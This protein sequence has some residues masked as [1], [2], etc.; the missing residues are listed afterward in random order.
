MYSPHL[1]L[2]PVDTQ[3]PQE[4]SLP[5]IGEPHSVG[6]T[7]TQG[8]GAPQTPLPVIIR[9]PSHREHTFS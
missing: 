1:T 8:R 4:H 5:R 9:L 2:S 3:S 6:V 7:I